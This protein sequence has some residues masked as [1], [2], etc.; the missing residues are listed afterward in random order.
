MPTSRLVAGVMTGTSI[1][2]IDVAIVRLEGRGLE[3]HA[4]LLLHVARPLGDLVA[5]LRDAA[6]Q[7]PLAARQF[8]ELG[9]AL[10]RLHAEVIA[11]AC[12]EAAVERLDLVAAHGQTVYHRPPASWQLLNA[13]PI[14]E[15]LRCRVVHDLRQA[16][17]AAYGQG[18][19]ITPLADWI[20]FRHPAR[21]R[22]IVNLGGFCN[23][24]LLPAAESAAI[25]E[26]LGAD[27]CAC[28][29][30]LDAVA[31]VALGLPFD[32]DG[33]AAASGTPRG[34]AVEALRH[35]LGCRAGLHRSLGTGDEASA[36]V[37]ALRDQLGPADL[38]ASAAAAVAGTIGDWLLSQGAEEVFLAGGGARHAALR[39]GIARS[40]GRPV[41][42]T[43]ELGVPVE[44]REAL[45]MAV[46]GALAEDGVAVTLPQ[47]TGRRDDPSPP[48]DG[49]WLG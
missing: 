8:A 39:D 18:A 21:R 1:D 25:H 43:A 15:A 42:T 16:D 11:E 13:A 27:V 47:V 31:R 36:W 3:L 48:R 22:A 2:A 5:P 26:I 38:A 34:D 32:P 6:E 19:P 49:S 29:L 12:R 4:E 14:V 30:V 40:A 28:N 23:C 17:L 45:D 46:L 7:R 9:L 35:S 10:G 41:A 37:A 24:T 44:S 33:A 20:L